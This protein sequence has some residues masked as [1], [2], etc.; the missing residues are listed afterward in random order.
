MA[1]RPGPAPALCHACPGT[2][3]L[4]PM[5]ME[6]VVR[7]AYAVLPAPSSARHLRR[8]LTPVPVRG[9]FGAPCRAVRVSSS[10]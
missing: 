3:D 8:S 4:R 7:A 6:L 2:Q 10:T 1:S 9:R 5:L